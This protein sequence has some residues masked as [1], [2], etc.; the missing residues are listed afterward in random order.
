MKITAVRAVPMSDPVPPERQH[1]TDLG[2]KVKSDATI[3]LVETD[4][5]LTGMGAGAARRR[6][7]AY[8]LDSLRGLDGF[9][10]A[11]LGTLR[12]NG[13]EPDSFLPEYAPQQ[14]E[15]SRPW[16]A[17]TAAIILPA[18]CHAMVT[19]SVGYRRPRPLRHGVSRIVRYVGW[20]RRPV[21]GFHRSSP[22]RAK[23]TRITI[24]PTLLN[25]LRAD[26]MPHHRSARAAARGVAGR[27]PTHPGDG[28]GRSR[29]SRR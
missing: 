21:A 9:A 4:E 10:N 1:R 26:V 25:P 23:A 29:G 16:T 18:T 13:I 22:L 11:V 7:D 28:P 6:G 12:E 8:A 19:S 3:L 14:F 24:R 27:A 17:A 5:R 15:V 2:T 20:A